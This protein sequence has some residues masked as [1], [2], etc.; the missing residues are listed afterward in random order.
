MIQLTTATMLE[1]AI[2]K[3]RMTKPFV[4][5]NQFGSYTVE[6]KQTGVAYIVECVKR[7]GKRFAHCTCK[8]G[9]RGQ[10]CY[11]VAA[12]ASA[13]IQLAAARSARNY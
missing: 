2:K 8:A 4:R 5:I 7:N 12:A 1:K 11:H 13:H 10:A 6:N 9:E 3:A